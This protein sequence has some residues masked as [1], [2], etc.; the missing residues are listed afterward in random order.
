M[1]SMQATDYNGTQKRGGRV[2]LPVLQKPDAGEP[3]HTNKLKAPPPS[4]A[5]QIPPLRLTRNQT[6]SLKYPMCNWKNG[7]ILLLGVWLS[8][9]V[10][11]EFKYL[12]NS[13]LDSASFLSVVTPVQITVDQ[14]QPRLNYSSA[15]ASTGVTAPTAG[16]NILIAVPIYSDGYTR[17][18]EDIIDAFRDVCEAGNLVTLLLYRTSLWDEDQMRLLRS[19][20][21]CH[22]GTFL[23]KIILKSPKVGF[24]LVAMHRSYFLNHTQD[25]D[26]FVYTENDLHVR[27]THILSY[28][29]ETEVIKGL[30]GEQFYQY[31]IG[32]ARYE[33]DSKTQE[34]HFWEQE[35]QWPVVRDPAPIA[36][37]YIT[38]P[39]RHHQ[40]MYMATSG[41]LEAWSESCPCFRDPFTIPKGPKGQ[42]Y[43]ERVS[44]MC[45]FE[46]CE[47]KQLLP[48]DSFED[49]AVHH[50]PN[51]Y[52][53]TPRWKIHANSS[54]YMQ[55][56]RLGIKS[57]QERVQ[58]WK[59]Q[60]KIEIINERKG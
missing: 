40:G 11:H 12:N 19:R 53:K 1:D 52:L 59:K 30:L 3:S 29:R 33:V 7:I 43:R 37:L 41:Q 31:S 6:P 24:D 45:L 42:Y 21:A 46:T 34:R 14:Q 27:L 13:Y 32:F 25:Y 4:K 22:R 23:L 18:V 17:H 9:S 51:K 60:S 39:L 47:I 36:G 57:D 58:K 44:S 20:A 15:S 8:I 54:K 26:L 38:M 35:G 2:P 49:H 55:T 50:M 48:I 5:S 56:F 28:M 10:A 16:L